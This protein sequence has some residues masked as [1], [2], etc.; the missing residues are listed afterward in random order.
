MK[1]VITL[2]L[3]LLSSATQSL[4]DELIRPEGSGPFPAVILMHSCGGIRPYHVDWGGFLRDNGYVSIVVDSFGPRGIEQM[5]SNRSS[6]APGAVPDRVKD[7]YKALAYLKTLPF[8]DGQRVAVMGWSHGG[9][10]ALEAV[11]G[12][13]V[14][15]FS[16]AVALYPDCRDS[17]AASKLPSLILVGDYDDW[18]PSKN[19]E[20]IKARTPSINLKVYPS[21][22]HS[23]DDPRFLRGTA[24]VGHM[25]QYNELATRDAHAQV[26]QFLG[27]YLGKP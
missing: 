27:K 11:T 2:L 26:L 16:A 23:F 22:Y 3:L 8:V 18:T 21:T 6:A 17:Q 15:K 7:A 9:T 14:E 12:E 10:T 20:A 19:C 24:Y 4:A 25:L 1:R 5:C 13:H